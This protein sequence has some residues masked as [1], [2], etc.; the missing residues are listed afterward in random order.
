M[1]II[2]LLALALTGLNV[3]GYAQEKQFSTLKKETIEFNFNKKVKSKSEITPKL[4][5]QNKLT[6]KAR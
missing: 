5:P 1:K 2:L 3:H 4:I 6:A